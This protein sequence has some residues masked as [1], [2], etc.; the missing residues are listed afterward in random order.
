MELKNYKKQTIWKESLKAREDS[1]KMA[2]FEA[3]LNLYEPNK[4]KRQVSSK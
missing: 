1:W 4:G 3:Q 2:G